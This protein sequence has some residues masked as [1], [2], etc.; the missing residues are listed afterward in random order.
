MIKH[1]CRKFQQI[2]SPRLK[3]L[4]SLINYLAALAELDFKLG[5]A[6][7]LMPIGITSSNLWRR[8]LA[9]LLNSERLGFQPNI[10]RFLFSNILVLDIECPE[11]D[12]SHKRTDNIRQFSLVA[13]KTAVIPGIVRESSFPRPEISS[14]PAHLMTRACTL[15]AFNNNPF[16][17]FIFSPSRCN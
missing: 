8:C 2:A 4:Y 10:S 15:G 13:I 11:Y 9:C 3:N 14:R 7:Q 17:I 5:E 1:D 16:V 12:G 6:A